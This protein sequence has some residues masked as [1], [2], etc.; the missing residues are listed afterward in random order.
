MCFFQFSSQAYDK[1]LKKMAVY[2]N[3]FLQVVPLITEKI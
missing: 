1:L 3:N 2:N